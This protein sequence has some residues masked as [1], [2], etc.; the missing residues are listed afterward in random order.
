MKKNILVVILLCVLVFTVTV[1]QGHNDEQST[2]AMVDFAKA[3]LEEQLNSDLEKGY[4]SDFQIIKW[5]FYDEGNREKQNVNIIYKVRIGDTWNGDPM[6]ETG[7]ISLQRFSRVFATDQGTME[8]DS[9]EHIYFQPENFM[10]EYAAIAGL[11]NSL[12]YHPYVAE[13][14]KDDVKN[15]ELNKIA[16]LLF[17]DWIDTFQEW[18][19]NSFIITE[20][21]NFEVGGIVEPGEI[22]SPASGIKRTDIAY[23][24]SINTWV[25]GMWC[26]FKII[27]AY[28]G[29]YFAESPGMPHVYGGGGTFGNDGVWQDSLVLK[30][31]KSFVLTEWEDRYTLET[32]CVCE[33]NIEKLNRVGGDM[34]ETVKKSL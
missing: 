6:D 9:E 22:E 12:W 7:L 5:E 21:K 11:N 13:I 32:A 19:N 25:V 28:D 4:I 29:G 24:G 26:D 16:S 18:G 20:Y 8:E 3:N 15:M 23:P 34:I 17:H 31:P 30:N 33:S 2:D 14:H 10:S 1:I 27:G